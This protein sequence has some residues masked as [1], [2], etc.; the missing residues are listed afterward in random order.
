MVLLLSKE[1]L[2]RP[3][4]WL[5]LKSRRDAVRPDPKLQAGRV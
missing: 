3:K 5:I 4:T 2:F 1:M